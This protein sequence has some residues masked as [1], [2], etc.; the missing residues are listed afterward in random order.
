MLPSPQFSI[1]VLLAG[2]LAVKKTV[3]IIHV[4]AG[5]IFS[6]KVFLERKRLRYL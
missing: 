2:Q 4:I 5:I 6:Q 1:T 3:S